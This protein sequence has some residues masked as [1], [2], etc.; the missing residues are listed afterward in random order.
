M[1]NLTAL[2]NR[3]PKCTALIAG[4]LSAFGFAPF[5][6]W[7]LTLIGLAGLIYLTSKA[8]GPRSAAING[9]MFGFGHFV[10]SNQWIAVTFNFQA[11]MPVWLGVGAVAA[12]AAYLAIYP[13]LT[14]SAAW[15]I[16]DAVRR[17]GG[18][19]TIPFALSFA[20]MWIITEWLRSWM[21]TG[22]A[23]NPIS[24]AFLN[25]PGVGAVRAIGTYGASGLALL[26]ASIL[27]GLIGAILTK[28]LKAVFARVF[29]TALLA[30]FC[31]AL[32][33]LGAGTLLPAKNQAITIVQPNISQAEKYELDY[34]AQNFAKLAKY[35]KPLPNETP[36]LLLWPEA[37]IPDYLES[38]YPQRYYQTQPGGS[39]IGARMRLQTLLSPGDILLTGAT[40]LVIDKD[41]QLIAARNSMIAMDAKTNLLGTYDK[42]HLVPYGEYLPLKQI[43]KP[44]GLARLVPGDLDFWPGTG[45]AT[46]DLSRSG[47]GSRAK[48]SIQICYEIIFSGQV[49]DRANR[50]DFIFNSSNDAWFG[51]IG[52][53]QH[54]AQAQLRAMEE[55]LPTVR[56]TPTGISAIIDADGRILKSLPLGTAG[57]I[58]G[59]VPP[60]RS[61]TWFA[62]AGNAA[63]LIFAALLLCFA[64]FPVVRRRT[65]R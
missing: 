7:P 41:R 38:G 30:G 50:S 4:A 56:S 22:Y 24:A 48:I 44:I 17:A 6:L 25:V 9:W 60:A 33:T 14:A 57:R 11:E 36:R 8:T 23:W 54:L 47:T 64:L 45:P 15:K 13:A 53:P 27:L 65:S 49:V 26:M 59:F 3:Y 37:A 61:A 32:G 35:S 62:R 40:R 19:P 58:D 21:F 16:G 10:I 43:L 5:G 12:L 51:R 2:L 42:A 52:P 46:M 29:D 31:A 28:Q 55:G 39:A 20:A 1:E 18:K 34:D 63:P